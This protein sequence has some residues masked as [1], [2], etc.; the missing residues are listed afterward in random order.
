MS[1]MSE[2]ISKAEVLHVADLAR[3]ELTDMEIIRMTEQM[4]NILGYMETLGRL[5]TT[6]IEPTTNAIQLYN[7]FR[8]DEIKESLDREQGLSNAPRSEGVSF[9]VPKVI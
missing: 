5:D 2:K 3:L 8:P 1:E 9:I 7:V 4:N 6:D